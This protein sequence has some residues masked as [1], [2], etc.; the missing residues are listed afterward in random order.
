MSRLEKLEAFLKLDP[1]DSF[2]RYAIGLE[3]ASIKDYPK[4]IAALETLRTADPAY[5][6]TYYQLADF[7]RQMKDT[8]QASQIYN[9]GIL[10][11]R[12]ARDLHAASEL[13]AALD[14]MES[15][16]F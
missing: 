13:E 16:E 9:L 10:V 12:Q 8:T 11:A 5:V 4:A 14:D 1:N 7:Y 2:T 6:P 3:Y 15:N